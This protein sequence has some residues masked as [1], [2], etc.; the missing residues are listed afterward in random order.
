MTVPSRHALV[1]H[2]PPLGVTARLTSALIVHFYG[3]E[4]LSPRVPWARWGVERGNVGIC[5]AG[6]GETLPFGHLVCG[7][8]GGWGGLVLPEYKGPA[9]LLQPLA[10][11]RDAPT[12]RLLL[13][14]APLALASLGTCAPQ[15]ISSTAALHPVVQQAC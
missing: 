8:G 6:Q 13:R 2:A 9:F 10:P 5:R 7:G 3:S 11:S 12:L 4:Y 14:S 15:E 1:L